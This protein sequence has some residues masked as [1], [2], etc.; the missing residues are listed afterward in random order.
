MQMLAPD[1]SLLTPSEILLFRAVKDEEERQANRNL[2]AILGAT[3]GTA[4]GAAAGTP[5][6]ILGNAL[7][8]LRNKIRPG[9]KANRLDPTHR[10]FKPGARFAGGLAGLIAG[11][12]LGAGVTAIANMESNGAAE[13]LAKM[14]LNELDEND[15]NRIENILAEVYT[16]PSELS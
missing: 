9:R 16:N 11:G 3:G 7:G 12:G 15:L 6:H 4:I 8:N 14:Q 1:E 13:L 2:G 10:L 5:F